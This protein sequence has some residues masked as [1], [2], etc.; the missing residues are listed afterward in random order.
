[1]LDVT[2]VVEAANRLY[3]RRDDSALELLIGMR[4][5]AIENNPA[6]ADKV[7]LE[8]KY[9]VETM[10]ALDDIRALGK[11]IVN[12]WNRE[13]CGVVC[14]AKTDDQKSREAILKSLNLSEIAV[15][16]TV[17]SALLSLGVTAA[18][19]AALSPIVVRKFIWPAKD[20]LCAAWTESL[21]S[22]I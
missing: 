5:K 21:N 3:E 19:A 10:G 1:M 20:E 12:R 7:D 13:L 22:S 16:A 4:E 8:P 14:G 2:V 11:R 17:T 9:E 15:I 6:L 18:I